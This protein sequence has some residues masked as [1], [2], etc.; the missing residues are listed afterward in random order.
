[1]AVESL[2]L[3]ACAAVWAAPPGAPPFSHRIH[4]GMQMQCAQCHTAAATS[5]NIADNLLPKKEVCLEC[6]SADEIP[7]IPAPVKTIVSQFSHAQHLK[8]GNVAPLIAKTIDKKTYLQAPGDIRRHL[9]G[10]NPCEA[11]HRGL[12]ESDQVT[13]TALPQMAD[14]LVCHS[15]IENPFSC[16]TCHA[17]DAPI[18][19]ASHVAHFMDLHSSG[20]LNLDKST[21]AVCHGREFTCMGCH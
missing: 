12:E 6:H 7:A 4:L 19:P 21:C 8:M 16:E 17:K 14:C 11:F 1:L 20:K 10:T 2:I 5:T 18:K 13:H 9:N 3:W 15:Q